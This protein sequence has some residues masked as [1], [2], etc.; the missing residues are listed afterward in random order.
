MISVSDRW[1]Y[2]TSDVDV[3]VR[4]HQANRFSD[5]NLLA[6]GSATDTVTW[7]QPADTLA[8]VYARVSFE[9]AC[10]DINAGASGV[11]TFSIDGERLNPTIDNR[12]QSR[13]GVGAAG[14]YSSAFG[15][16][17]DLRRPFVLFGDGAQHELTVQTTASLGGCGDPVPFTWEFDIVEVR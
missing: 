7:T 16:F 2:V 13:H 6:G 17:D 11:W 12:L 8:V 1:R 10:N 15:F 9:Y 5:T 14:D 4:S 3:K